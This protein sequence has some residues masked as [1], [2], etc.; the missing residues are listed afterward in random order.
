VG[1]VFLTG[2]VN[3]CPIHHF[4]FIEAMNSKGFPVGIEIENRE[5]RNKFSSWDTPLLLKMNLLF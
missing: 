2:C 5:D 4:R 1:T 3:R